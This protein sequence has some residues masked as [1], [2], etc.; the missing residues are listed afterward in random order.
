MSR[1]TKQE[2]LQRR[3]PD[4]QQVHEK[5]LNITNQGNAIKTTVNYHFIPVRID[6]TKKTR[7]NKCW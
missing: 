3:H 2:F 5:M 1:E 6:I 7:G 4:D